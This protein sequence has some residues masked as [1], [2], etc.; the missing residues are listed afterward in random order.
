M[1][2]DLAT[3]LASLE[4]NGAVV[5]SEVAR[6][7]AHWAS[8]LEGIE[9][10]LEQVTGMPREA[11]TGAHP[12][13]ER[14]LAELATRLDGMERD[15]QAVASE[16]ARASQER[17]AERSALEARLD[18]VATH[19]AEV[20]S[21][22]RGAA[23]TSSA[24]EVAQL[25]VAVDGLRMRLASSEQE[26]ATLVGAR[27]TATRIDELTR[28]LESLERAP[29]VIA[30]SADGGPLPGDGRFRLELRALELRMEH[31]ELAA[32]ENREAV[33]VQLERLAA[34][35]EWRFQRLEA[36]YE[37]SHPRAIGGGGQVVPIRPAEA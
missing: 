4:E 37:A 16:I 20:E 12:E 30:G 24:D 23:P 35:I 18:E 8:E 1:L 11:A 14:V 33:L 17:Q 26:L 28:R 15:R 3:R 2:N 22:T 21:D 27:D 31:A 7:A 6:T 13:T 19:L 5:A 34:R 25:R 10:R 29:V 32:R 9:T 36:E